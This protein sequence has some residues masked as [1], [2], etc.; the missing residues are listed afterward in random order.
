MTVNIALKVLEFSDTACIKSI[1]LSYFKWK[2][3]DEVFSNS[4]L[5]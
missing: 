4:L 5:S 1:L 3:M 2:L